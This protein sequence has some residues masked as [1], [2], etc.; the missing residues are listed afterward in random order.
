MATKNFIVL[1]ERDSKTIYS[2]LLQNVLYLPYLVRYLG[3]Y[4][5]VAQQWRLQKSSLSSFSFSQMLRGN[6]LPAQIQFAIRLMVEKLRMHTILALGLT[7]WVYKQEKLIHLGQKSYS[8]LSLLQI[9]AGDVK[10]CPGRSVKCF[11][12][13]S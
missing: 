1:F 4:F 6:L 8:G 7:L 3:D 13:N 11:S 12:S 10:L 5:I 9:L 2:S